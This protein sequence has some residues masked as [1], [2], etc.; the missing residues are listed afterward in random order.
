MDDD[1]P[2]L[3]LTPGPLTTSRSVRQAMLSVSET[4]GAR[5][6]VYQVKF[7]REQNRDALLAALRDE[8]E[9][10][11]TRLLLQDATSEY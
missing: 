9:A 10:D 6:L 1:I 7:F 5:E 11:D 3:L 8:L 4:Q 2:Y